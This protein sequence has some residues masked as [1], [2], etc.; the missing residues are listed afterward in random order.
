MAKTKHTGD[1]KRISQ[2]TEALEIDGMINAK[3][4]VAEIN[5]PDFVDEISTSGDDEVNVVEMVGPK[6]SGGMEKSSKDSKKSGTVVTQAFRVAETL[7]ESRKPRTSAATEALTSLASVFSPASMRE[8]DEARM[9]MSLQ[10][11]HLESQQAEVRELRARN[12]ELSDRI[13]AESRRADRADI[14]KTVLEREVQSLR[15]QLAEAERHSRR[16]RRYQLS[17]DEEMSNPQ[18]PGH[19]YVRRQH[20]ASPTPW[21]IVDGRRSKSSGSLGTL[22]SVASDHYSSPGAHTTSAASSSASLP[23]TN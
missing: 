13:L 10:L 14:E 8:R 5:D 9:G 15:G 19:R 1:P 4:H 22:A 12:I 2:L 23:L 18:H 11:A 3:A 21:D 7:A 6:P 20:V 17:S 16:R